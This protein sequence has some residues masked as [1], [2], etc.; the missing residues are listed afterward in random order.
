M[1]D[2]IA[3]QTSARTYV[4]KNKIYPIDKHLHVHSH[5]MRQNLFQ[6]VLLVGWI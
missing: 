4:E 5:S 1:I 2:G 6:G 3:M